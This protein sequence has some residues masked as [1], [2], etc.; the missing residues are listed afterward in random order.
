M[1]YNVMNNLVY[2]KLFFSIKHALQQDAN[3][4]Q[5]TFVLL[6]TASFITA[7]IAAAYKMPFQFF[8]RN[9]AAQRKGVKWLDCTSGKAAYLKYG[10]I[11]VDD[12]LDTFIKF[13]LNDVLIHQVHALPNVSIA[14]II[15]LTT[16]VATAPMD[17]LKT[18]IL[19]PSLAPSTIRLEHWMKGTCIRIISTVFNAIIFMSLFNGLQ[20]VI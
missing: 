9:L 14:C 17:V 15:G 18:W 19:I 5:S 13:F 12:T 1:T 8:L 16:A 3:I 4:R 20:M 2:Y 10:I 11:V 7:I 6:L